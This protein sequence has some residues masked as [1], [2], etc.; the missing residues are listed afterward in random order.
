MLFYS[1]ESITI[2]FEEATDF[3]FVSKPEESFR[4]T[5]HCAKC[6]EEI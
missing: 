5:P 2:L 3:Q 6:K 4:D 1:N